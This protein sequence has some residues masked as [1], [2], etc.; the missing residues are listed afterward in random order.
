[1]KKHQL[2]HKKKLSLRGA[3]PWNVEESNSIGARAGDATSGVSKSPQEWAEEQGIE[4]E[5]TFALEPGDPS[6]L[7]P[8]AGSPDSDED[9]SPGEKGKERG[10]PRRR[11]A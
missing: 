2:K 7:Q 11:A 10:R 9:T 3:L 5:P 6:P 8:A 4:D 1:M